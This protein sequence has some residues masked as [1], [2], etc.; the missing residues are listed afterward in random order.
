LFYALSLESVPITSLPNSTFPAQF[1]LGDLTFGHR[2]QFSPFLFP[3][4][5]RH[6]FRRHTRKTSLT[7]IQCQK[8][9]AT[10]TDLFW[11]FLGPWLFMSTSLKHL[12]LTVFSLLLT[13]DFR[14]L[15]SPSRFHAAWFASFWRQVG[16]SVFEGSS[17]R[18]IPLLEGRISNAQIVPSSSANPH[19]PLSGTV[20]EIGAGTGMWA[21]KLASFPGVTKVYGVEPNLESAAR[22]R[23]LIKQKGLEGKY[24]VVP[25]GIED[26]EGMAEAGLELGSVDCIVT[27]LCL[28]SIPEPAQ[29]I[30][31]LYGYL[32]PGGRWYSYDHVRIGREYPWGIRAY[33]CELDSSSFT[34]LPRVPC[35]GQGHV[36]VR[37]SG[38]D[39][40]TK[41][42]EWLLMSRGNSF[43][44]YNLVVHDLVLDF[45][46]FGDVVEGG[47]TVVQN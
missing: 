35:S 23:Q 28:C 5:H 19:P 11:G 41:R 39:L 44:G 15:F 40:D 32:K 36:R 4:H 26:T 27:V 33:Q 22:L 34:L 25:T 10:L 7:I 29:N 45:E 31:R 12:P 1:Y 14:T 30:K 9:M 6:I 18:A 16:P 3:S 38:V 24:V 20:L 37:A 17:Q 47:G 46:G 13:G 43:G 2:Y 8:T 21:A 42:D